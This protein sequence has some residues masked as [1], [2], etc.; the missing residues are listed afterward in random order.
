MQ[1]IGFLMMFVLYL[2]CGAAYNTLSTTEIHWFQFLYFMS[3]Y[4]NQFGPNCTTWLVAGEVY[5]TDVRAFFHGISAA[6]GKAGAIAATQIFSRI[7]TADTFYVS[8]AAGIAGALATLIFLPDTTGL[9]LG[10]LD[11]FNMYLL[12]GHTQ[13]YHGEAVNPKYLSYFERWMGWGKS[14]NPQLDK[15]QKKLQTMAR[16]HMMPVDEGDEEEEERNEK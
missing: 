8:A 1:M 15:D 12:A 2:P 9:D 5:P 3:S 11:R 10:E 6:F 7:A 14:Y 4:F 16:T 13:H